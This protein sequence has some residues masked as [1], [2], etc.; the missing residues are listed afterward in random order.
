MFTFMGFHIKQDGYG[1]GT[2][3]IAEA[4]RRIDSGVQYVDMAENGRH[5][6]PHDKAWTI[7]GTAIALCLPDWYDDVH[8]DRLIGFT[9]HEATRLPKDWVEIINRRCERVIVPCEWNVQVFQ[10]SG[11]RAPID[12]ARWG[13]DA[14]DYWPVEREAFSIQH[15]AISEKPYT[16]LWSGTPDLRKGWDVAYLAFNLAFGKRED[17]QLILHFRDALPGDP[18]FADRNVRAVVG[19]LDTYGWRSKL[20]NADCFVFPSRGEGWGLPPREAAATGLPTIATNWGGLHE[21]ID[22]WGLAL[23]VKR[24]SPASYGWWNA[25]DVGEWAEP[26]IDHLVELMRWCEANRDQAAQVGERAAEWLKQN[27]PWERT[28]KAVMKAVGQAQSQPLR[29]MEVA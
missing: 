16:F 13:I 8:C 14:N 27:T 17:V 24:M 9:M 10:E 18:R 26:D 7:P 4:L 20:A 2:L 28:A 3:K 25:G 6:D 1:Y 15:S 22:E 29:V 5:V 21:E 19:R 12:V 11:V 23:D